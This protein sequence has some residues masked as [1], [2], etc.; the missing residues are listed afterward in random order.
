MNFP[1]LTSAAIFLTVLLLAA[2]GP[3][4]TATSIAGV[5][6]AI[7]SSAT[8]AFTNTPVSPATQTLTSTVSSSPDNLCAKANKHVDI[9]ANRYHGAN[10]HADGHQDASAN[11]NPNLN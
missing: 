10:A 6:T 1:R 2:C 11:S 3:G 7:K 8:P 4:P 5:P 9:R